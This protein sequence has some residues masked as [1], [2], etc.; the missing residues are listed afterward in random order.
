[1]SNKAEY[2]VSTSVLKKTYPLKIKVKNVPEGPIFKPK[3]KVFNV[4][5]G[6]ETRIHTVIAR[7][8]AVDGDTFEIAKDVRLVTSP[9]FVMHAWYKQ[10][11]Y[12]SLLNVDMLF[13]SICYIF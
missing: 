2:H 7:Y 12:S 11:P 10:P 3:L 9:C 1:M 6:T 5:E 13:M 4:S 8:P